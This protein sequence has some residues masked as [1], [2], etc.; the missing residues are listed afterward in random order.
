MGKILIVAEKPSAGATIANVV[1]ANQKNDGYLEG[2][3][4][5]VTWGL[6][7]LI[8]LKEPDEHD[9]KYAKWTMQDLPLVF[10]IHDSL[11]VIP[12]SAHQFKVVKNLIHRDDIDYLINAGDAG[13]EGYLIQKWIYRMSSSKLKEKVLW[14]SSLTDQGILD[15]LKKLKDDDDPLFRTLLDEAE[16]RA[17]GD[18]LL[19][20]NYSRLLTLTRAT[21]RTTLSYGRCQ[22]P[23]L[24][25]VVE[26]ENI[27]SNFKPEPFWDLQVNYVSG[28]NGT[29]IDDNGKICHFENEEEIERIKTALSG[30]NGIITSYISEEKSK[31]APAL[32]NLAKLQ[33]DMG[34]KYKYSP[35]KTLKICQSLYEKHKILSYPRTDSRYLSMDIYNEIEE[36]VKCC[37]FGPFISLVDH[38]DLSNIAPDKSYFN[39]HKVTDHHALIPTINEKMG[40][41]YKELNDDERKV[42][43]SVV[44]SLLAIFY[45]PYRYQATQVIVNISD[46]LFKSSGNVLIDLGYKSIYGL[47]SDKDDEQSLPHMDEGAEIKVESLEILNKKTSPPGYLNDSSIIKLMEKYNIGTSATRAEIINKLQNPRRQFMIR[48]DKDGIYRATELGKAYISVVPKSLKSV[49]FTQKFETGLSM[50]NSGQISKKDFLNALIVEIN[51]NINYFGAHPI[52]EEDKLGYGMETTDVLGKCPKCGALVKIGKFGIYCENKCGMKLDKVRGVTLKPEQVKSLLRG[53]KISLSGLKKKDGSGTYSAY[54][55]PTGIEAYSYESNGKTYSGYQF[56]FETEFKK[57]RKKKSDSSIYNEL[58]KVI[59]DLKSGRL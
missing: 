18:Y 25:L 52:A 21:G 44:L 27:M 46:Y 9:E 29:L 58:D 12:E 51:N 31:K 53:E 59:N 41:I 14:A 38:L 3:K 42:F 19:G 43:D 49:E 47:E 35:D 5:V 11:K 32:F 30:K 7:H 55:I 23:L 8:G 45:P 4:Y 17:E 34:K 24:N 36:H 39:D 15:A 37:R 56:T 1:G 48:D 33:A 54:F 10:N 16:A 13:R 2:E 6:G 22:T 20:M 57:S 50:V 26:R 40:E 28:F